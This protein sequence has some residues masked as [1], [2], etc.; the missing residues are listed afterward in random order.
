[1]D[2]DDINFPNANLPFDTLPGSNLPLENNEYI[3]Q[4]E[5][6]VNLGANTY[7]LGLINTNYFNSSRNIE[8]LNLCGCTDPKATNYKSYYVKN[9]PKKCKFDQ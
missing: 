8:L 2:E 5:Q 6:P 7:D 9:D 1:M 3:I 4:Y